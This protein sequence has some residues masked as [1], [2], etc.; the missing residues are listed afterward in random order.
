MLIE[1][2]S[3]YGEGPC[4]DGQS[5]VWI[6]LGCGIGGGLDKKKILKCEDLSNFEGYLRITG[7][8]FGDI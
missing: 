7:D 6:I 3:S 4:Y 1:K 8:G 5:A 2:E